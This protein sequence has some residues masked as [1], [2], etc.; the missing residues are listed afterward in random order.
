M[1]TFVITALATGAAGA[2]A[3]GVLARWAIVQRRLAVTARD[4]LARSAAELA[5]RCDEATSGEARLRQAIESTLQGVLVYDEHGA[6]V[7]RNKVPGSL[8]PNRS[9][10]LLVRAAIDE[11]V[12]AA[13][14]GQPGHR[15][16]DVFGP[17]RR[18][19]NIAARPLR[20]GPRPLG[21]VVVIEDVSDKRRLEAMRRDFVAN[22]SHE[23][24]TPIGALGLL[25]ETLAAEDDPAVVNHLAERMQSEAFRVARTIDDLLE[26]SRIESSDEPIREQ[27]PVHRV[28]GEA[29]DRMR[30]AAQQHRI[31]ID[32]DDVDRTATVMGD[33][34]ELV[35]ALYNL[36][37]NAVKYS[38][39]GS[40][41]D[42]RVTVVG[43]TV[44]IAVRD[45]GV[46]IPSTDLE[47]I[48]ERFYRVDHGRS[49]TTGGTGLG[50]SIVRHVVGNHAGQVLVQSREG[51]GSTF[52]LVLP[53]SEPATNP[54]ESRAG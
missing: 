44:E 23:L 38:G 26:L 45:R 25:A 21:A 8:A 22:V 50:L 36:L 15:S 11:L 20:A 39:P 5:Q 49:R 34:R 17:P 52:T 37:D 42:V 7:Y 6:V 53:A 43:E 19:L 51:E 2:A 41:V 29:A 9:G 14:E 24:K 4:E 12:R 18:S 16:V 35:S 40:V 3:A 48:F 1:R 27:V 32:S 30:P 10:D 13:L 28:V 31:D 47:R 33:R 46:G 54:V